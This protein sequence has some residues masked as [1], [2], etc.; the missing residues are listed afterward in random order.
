ML[1]FSVCTTYQLLEAITYKENYNSEEKVVLLISKWLAEKYTWYHKLEKFFH[2]IIVFNGSY[3][4]DTND[5]LKTL[6]PYFENLLIENNIDIN[7]MDEI[8]VWGCE[9]S[10]GIYISS[11]NIPY[12]FWEEGN[13]ALENIDN[14][15][16]HFR[17]IHGNDK[18]ELFMKL[19]VID[20]CNKC[21]IKKF[22]NNKLNLPDV[23]NFNLV[24]EIAKLKLDRRNLLVEM[25][26]GK[27]E[28]DTDDNTILV[29]TEHLSNLGIMSWNE[30]IFMYQLLLDYFKTQYTI[31]F[32]PHP[33]DLT[34]YESYFKDCKVLRKSFPAELLPYIW[35]QKPEILFTV[36]STSI[37]DLKNLFCKFIEFDF[38]Y[39]HKKK[40]YF[41]HQYYI[42]LVY[43]KRRMDNINVIYTLGASNVCINNLLNL[44]NGKNEKV[45]NL[46]GFAD[47]KKIVHKDCIIFIDDISEDYEF[48]ENVLNLLSEQM[49]KA[50]VV[51]LGNAVDVIFCSLN[52][53]K[54]FFNFDVVEIRKNKIND[55]IVYNSLN[56]EYIYVF[57]KGENFNMNDI[58]YSL[59]YTGIEIEAELLGDDKRKI[60]ILEAMLA[61]SEKRLLYYIEKENNKE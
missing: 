59:P 49:I 41:I 8:H 58:K 14:M 22:G 55:N 6:K 10:F 17:E 51:F 46:V 42:S 44:K 11:L 2:K 31:L 34:D 57:N 56:N 26:F 40:F 32:K 37:Y 29:L 50:T 47:L 61:A 27:G 35:A 33:D 39:S 12:Y 7:K 25:F 48:I 53:K 28:I 23:I 9:H 5:P 4:Y 54:I 36:S 45:K 19:G 1:L 30:Q 15:K 21:V 43:L 24:D 38:D 60:K 18:I 52:H 16:V 20:G 13:G 3:A